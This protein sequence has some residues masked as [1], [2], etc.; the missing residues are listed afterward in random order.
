MGSAKDWSRSGFLVSATLIGVSI[1]CVDVEALSSGECDEGTK[2]CNGMCV[3]FDD[4]QTGCSRPGCAP[5][6]L[7]SASSK[8]SQ[9]DQVCVVAIC[10]PGRDDC[11]NDASNGCETDIYG[12]E[13]NCGACRDLCV[14]LEGQNYEPTCRTGDCIVGT[15]D[16]GVEDCDGITAN[17][18]ET[19]VNTDENCG[20]CGN[21]CGVDE[22]CA[23]DA[24][25]TAWM[26]VPAL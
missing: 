14:R 13:M 10:N 18:C 21:Q 23:P 20:A 7:E 5:C 8:C 22:M 25:M 24:E 1:A 9:V 16:P 26:C 19:D 17:G 15:C 6:V 2:A 12:D 11:D 3:D 4:P